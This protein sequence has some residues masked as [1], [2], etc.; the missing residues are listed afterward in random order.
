VDSQITL[1]IW[2]K[3]DED[4]KTHYPLLYHMLDTAAICREIWESCLHEATKVWL[5][6]QL[7]LDDEIACR[8]ISFWA[9]LHDIGKAT[10]GFQ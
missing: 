4:N 2:A 6:N 1:D 8:Q 10:P 9:G 7:R 5:S 3:K